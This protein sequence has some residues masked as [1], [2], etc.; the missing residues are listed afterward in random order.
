MSRLKV[1]I[2]FRSKVTG[3]YKTVSCLHCRDNFATYPTKNV[4]KKLIWAKYGDY[5]KREDK[6]DHTIC[7]GTE[8]DL[9]ATFKNEP[10]I[11]I[12]DY[13][14]GCRDKIS[15]IVSDKLNT[16]YI[17]IHYDNVDVINLGSKKLIR[18]N[19]FI[20]NKDIDMLWSFKKYK[21]NEFN[22]SKRGN[23][24]LIIMNESHQEMDWEI[25]Y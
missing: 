1:K 9:V 10:D 3:E 20:H 15:Q 21:M 22:Y 17:Y 16:N 4:D 24:S 2:M 19:Q 12:N 18:N 25:I 7:S 13:I 14:F 5:Y 6:F 11:I 23:V 8:Y